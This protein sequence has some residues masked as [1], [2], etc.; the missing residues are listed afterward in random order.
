[1]QRWFGQRYTVAM[2]RELTSFRAM[3]YTIAADADRVTTKAM[4]VSVGNG[5]RYGGGMHICPSADIHDGLLDVTVLA[6]VSRARL[7][8]SFRLVFSGAH[9]RLPFVTT[10][11]AAQ[12]SLSSNGATAYADG[13]RLG[14]LPITIRTMPGALS[15]V[16][17]V[18]DPQG[19]P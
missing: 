14:P 2:L 19:T 9:V 7:L 8:W 11:R 13:E 3:S 5:P 18:L 17:G 6:Q 4:I 1:M 12:V 16:G 10:M 15:V